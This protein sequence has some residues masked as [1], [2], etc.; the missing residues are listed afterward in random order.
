MLTIQ[1]LCGFVFQIWFLFPVSASGNCNGHL[2]GP[3]SCLVHLA[4]DIMPSSLLQKIGFP[5]CMQVMDMCRGWAAYSYL[6][7]ELLWV[8]QYMQM[9][10]GIF[11]SIWK[12]FKIIWSL[13]F[14]QIWV[15]YGFSSVKYII[16][17]SFLPWF[18]HVPFFYVY[19]SQIYW[20][21]LSQFFLHLRKNNWE[22]R[23]CARVM[24]TLGCVP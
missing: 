4:D 13:Q 16:F 7:W 12:L 24:A 11:S 6:V 18:S 2:L 22:K 1:V 9:Y 8:S 17:F 14:C 21:Y 3:Q 23:K 20:W 10:K 5:V 15:I 19:F